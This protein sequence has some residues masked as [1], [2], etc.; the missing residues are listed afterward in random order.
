MRR[1]LTVIS[2]AVCVLAGCAGWAV[3]EDYDSDLTPAREFERF[4]LFY[5][6]ERFEG[7][8]VTHVLTSRDWGW[9]S[10]AFIYGDC[11][12]PPGGSCAPPLEVQDWSICVR[13]P[14]L[15]PGHVRTFPF[16]GAKAAWVP[17]AGSFEVYTGKTAAVIFADDRHFAKRAGRALLDVRETTI[18]KRLA[19]PK[20][21]SLRGHL[22][23]QRGRR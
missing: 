15:Y 18:P 8:E 9:K 2:A 14:K 4:R 6:G 3:A 1:L 13:F 16:R 7:L 10:W 21:G 22:A 5:A 19:P 12:P 11:V 17:T 23:C 20:R